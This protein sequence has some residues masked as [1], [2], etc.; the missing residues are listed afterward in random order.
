MFLDEAR[1]VANIHHPNVIGIQEIGRAGGGFYLV[2]DYVKGGTLAQVMAWAVGRN[3]VPPV[4]ITIRIMLD[5]LA[6]LHA[7]HELT[8]ENGEYVALIHRDVSPQNILV[9][10]DGVTRIADFGVARATNRLGETSG[11]QLKGKLAYMAPEQ[12][13]GESG[14]T[15]QVDIFAAGICLWEALSGER[16]FKGENEAA[17]LVKVLNNSA[18]NL[19]QS[20]RS[21]PEAISLV[22][23]QALERNVADR[24]RDCAEFHRELL[25]AARASGSLGTTQDVAE[26]IGMA[27]ADELRSHEDA[28][29]TW[30]G[31]STLNR[32]VE[33]LRA[34]SPSVAPLSSI[35]PPACGPPVSGVP[36]PSASDA[37]EEANTAPPESVPPNF[38]PLSGGL[39]SL[40]P[41]DR[42]TT[43]PPP[44]ALGSVSVPELPEGSSSL[45][46]SG[47]Q[48]LSSRPPLALDPGEY[49]GTQ[50]DFDQSTWPIVVIRFPKGDYSAEMGAFFTRILALANGPEPFVLII[51]LRSASISSAGGRRESAEFVK[52]AIDLSRIRGAALISNARMIRGAIK[53]I[54]WLAPVPVPVCVFR[55]TA[56]AQAWAEE[57]ATELT[58]EREAELLYKSTRP[59][60]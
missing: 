6:G 40:S 56:E 36:P 18:P 10:A 45:P 1:L 55:D 22:C 17:S 54:F 31:S 50:I 16:L 48:S 35:V 24:Y 49:Q 15:R 53:A 60:P 2:M 20:Y 21:V 57:R 13:R 28:I 43:M 12:A 37:P 26:F 11:G 52:N 46:P 7:A 5:L 41:D 8:T 32:R 4:G 59:G 9:G 39:A 25:A 30:K 44:D 38:S 51:D 34:A 3:E 23:N 47:S 14:I 29:R 27:M 58:A 19:H 42:E 33:L